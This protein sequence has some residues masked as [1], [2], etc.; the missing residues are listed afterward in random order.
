[1]VNM[2]MAGED[3]AGAH[4]GGAVDDGVAAGLLEEL[5]RLDALLDDVVPGEGVRVGVRDDRRLRILRSAAGRRSSRARSGTARKRT[6]KA[7]TTVELAQRQRLEEEDKPEAAEMGEKVVEEGEGRT[8]VKMC[9]WDEVQ[10]SS[11]VLTS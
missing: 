1:M 9:S 7:E 6:R 4:D 5:E 3:G 11:A 8:L 10:P 2:M